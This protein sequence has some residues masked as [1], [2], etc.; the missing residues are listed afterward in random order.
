L[1]PGE[2]FC[3]IG[4]EVRERSPLPNTLFLA[5]SNGSIGYVPT[6]ESYPEGGYE[7]SHACRVGP[8]AAGT[9]VEA[10]L[11]ALRQCA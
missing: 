5:Y 3:E 9:I 8:A 4:M 7:V 1:T 10:S 11:A 6:P 2:V